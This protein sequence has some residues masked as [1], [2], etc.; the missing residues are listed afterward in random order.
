LNGSMAGSSFDG[1]WKTTPDRTAAAVPARR[2]D[3]PRPPA[4]AATAI[5]LSNI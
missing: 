3:D 2:A 5:Y 4:A 1:R